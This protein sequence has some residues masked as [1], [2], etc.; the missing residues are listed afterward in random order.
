V[1]T[2]DGELSLQCIRPVASH[3]IFTIAPEEDDNLEDYEEVEVDLGK[4]ELRRGI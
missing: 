2:A 4:G 3:D 1:E